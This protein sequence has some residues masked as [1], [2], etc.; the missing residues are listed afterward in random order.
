MKESPTP[1]GVEDKGRINC[2]YQHLTPS[3]V[4]E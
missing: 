3:G 2:F 1:Y 4:V